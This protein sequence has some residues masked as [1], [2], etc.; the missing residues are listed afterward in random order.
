MARPKLFSLSEE[1]EIETPLEGGGERSSLTREMRSITEVIIVVTIL[2]FL[3]AFLVWLISSRSDEIVTSGQVS[4][5]CAEGQ[6]PTNLQT[7]EKRCPANSAT[8]VLYD[9]RVEVCNSRYTCENYLTPYAILPDG[10][11]NSLG[12]CAPGE[13]CRCVSYAQC[14]FQNVVLFNMSYGSI[15]TDPIRSSRV[16]FVQVS[17]GYQGAAGAVTLTYDNPSTQFC[18]L[19]AYHLNRLSPGACFYRDPQQPTIAEVVTCLQSNPCVI[20]VLAFEPINANTFTLTPSNTNAIYSIPV[21]CVPGDRVNPL[22]TGT[23]I[24]V[25][26]SSSGA[27]TCYDTGILPLAQ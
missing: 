5:Y 12:A 14:P 17:L 2:V 18:A 7:G 6:C 11:T 8:S 20:G 1:E 21:A 22:C 25:W 10:S 27:L 4:F 23:K 24:P 26:D 16:Q 9:P 3:L 19:K 13:T 15:Y